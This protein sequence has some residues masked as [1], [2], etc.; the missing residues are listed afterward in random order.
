MFQVHEQY[1]HGAQRSASI[2][3][4]G[5][6]GSLSPKPYNAKTLNP[7]LPALGYLHP[8]GEVFWEVSGMGVRASVMWRSRPPSILCSLCLGFRGSRVLGLYRAY[9]GIMEEKTG[10]T[11]VYY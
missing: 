7:K 1:L 4:I 8:P 2:A 3:H 10:T 6:F 11:I 5:L 9:I